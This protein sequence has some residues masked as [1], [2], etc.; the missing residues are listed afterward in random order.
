MIAPSVAEIVK[1][2]VRLTVEGI[3]RMYLNVYVPACKYDRGDPAAASR[4]HAPSLHS[5]SR[6]SNSPASDDWLPPLKSTV[7]FLRHT[8]GRSKGSGVS[9]VM[10]A[11]ALG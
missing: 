7:S 4:P 11:V 3:D 10:A 9:S 1:R 5:A 8:A 2:H 6:S